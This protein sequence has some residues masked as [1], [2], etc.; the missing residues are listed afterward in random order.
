MAGSVSLETAAG[1]TSELAGDLKGVGKLSASGGGALKVSGKVT[2]D[3]GV[4]EVVNAQSGTGGITKNGEGTLKWSG[5]GSVQG[6]A[7]VNGGTLEVTGDQIL[8]DVT[9][10]G[11]G[12]L[13]VLGN[14]RF[15]GTT[16]LQSGTIVVDKNSA[17]AKVPLLVV[18]GKDSSGTVLDVSA[19]P[20]GLIVGPNSEQTLK[21]KGTILGSVSIRA[22]GVVEPG[23]SIDTLTIRATAFTH[24]L[25]DFTIDPGATFNAEYAYSAL[26]GGSSDLIRVTSDASG[27]FGIAT[28]NGGYVKPKVWGA[29][30]L[31]DFAPHAFTILTAASGVVGNFDGIYQTAVIQG[32]LGTFRDPLVGA[33]TLN[34]VSMVLQRVPYE[35]LG[36][37]GARSRFGAALDLNLSTV[38]PALSS[39]LDLLDGLATQAQVQAV[40]ER[41]NPSAYAEGYGLSASRLQDVQ[42]TLSDRFTSLA[43]RS[44]L[45]EGNGG[46]DSDQGGEWTAWT[47]TYGGSAARSAGASQNGGFS[48]ST[49]GSMTGVEHPFGPMILGLFGAAGSA[50]EQLNRL[51]SRITSDSWHMGLYSSLP[52]G[53]RV[54][55]NGAAIYGQSENVFKRSL[56]GLSLG[57]VG[58]GKMEGEETLFHLGM[59]VQVA[60]AEVNWSA[61]LGAEISYGLV[62]SGSVRESGME[63]LGAD[64]SAASAATMFS[65]LGFE[66]AKELN[67]KGV[68]LRFA[69]NASWLHDFEAD[70]KT[71]SVRMQIP[72]AS[73]WKIESERRAVDALRTGLSLEWAVGERKT[74]KIYGDQQFQS[75]GHVLRGGVTFTVGF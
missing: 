36:G 45:A 11:S 19:A 15:E 40:L 54:S 44:A 74:L 61:V 4:L 65:R 39:L 42:K 66:L 50:N 3:T 49:Y 13:E 23:N 67:V 53:Q 59:D 22:Y 30:R 6:A 62:R 16:V 51:E 5:A 56:S 46:S 58:R 75:G 64:V 31:P 71:L 2:I 52:V 14:S 18:G 47:N 33:G 9:K 63:A 43:G 38:D 41:T 21:G 73:A 32:T 20:T 12:K 1:A 34:S 29:G 24:A 7:Q 37:G 68:P 28:I 48:S 60:P 17:L 25:G 27:A 69:G 8:I 55:L 57:A 70:P 35:V 10:L 26:S 72:G